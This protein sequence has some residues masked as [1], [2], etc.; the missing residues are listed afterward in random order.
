[1][2][3]AIDEG[4]TGAIFALGLAEAIGVET[5][6]RLVDRRELAPDVRVMYVD[7]TGPKES[8]RM[9]TLHVEVVTYTKHSA[10][11]LGDFLFTV[12]LD[13][14]KKAYSS[15]TVVVGFVQRGASPDEVRSAHTELVERGAGGLCYVIGRRD[16]CRFQVMQVVPR[17]RGPQEVDLDEAFRSTQ[18]PVAEMKRG[19]SPDS[20]VSEAPIPT[21]NPFL[22]LL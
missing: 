15:D 3:T 11:G 17:L 19:M 1:M 12:K 4:R 13:P 8:H 6:I 5:W 10:E 16:E 9:N 18:A 20:A 2:Q 7:N 21:A 14:S 22:E